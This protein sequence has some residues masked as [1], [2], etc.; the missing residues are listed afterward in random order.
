[1]R[2]K[3]LLPPLDPIR[4]VRSPG[5]TRLDPLEFRNLLTGPASRVIT[6]EKPSLKTD[7][8][9]ETDDGTQNRPN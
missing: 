5:P 9:T 7:S 2:F 4:L 3:N 6:C 1:M 8:D